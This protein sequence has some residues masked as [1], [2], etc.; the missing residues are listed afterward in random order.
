M[1][2]SLVI[3]ESPGKIKKISKFL[4]S[5]YI[6]KASVGHIADLASGRLNVDIEGGFKPKYTILS[7]KKQHVKIIISAAKH[8]EKIFLATDDDREGEAI[9]W[10]LADVLK[11]IDVPIFRVKFN[12]ITKKGVLNGINNP[13]ELDHNLYDAQ[14]AR[15]VLDRIVGFSVSPFLIK[16]FKSGFSAGRVQSVAVRMVVDK[17]KEIEVFQPEEYWVITSELAKAENK[18]DSFT[19]KYAKKVTNGDIAKKIKEDLDKDTYFVSE[20]IDNERKKKPYPPFI[21]S[22]LASTAA[23]KYKL[24][25]AKTM[26]AAQSL[27]ES[28]MITYIRT[29]SIRLSEDSIS[30]CRDWL[31]SNGYDIPHK[32]VIYV[33]KKGA[34]D[35]HEAIR[36]TDVNFTPKNVFLEKDEQLIY[37]LIWER[38]VACQMNPAVYNNVVVTIS[39]SSGHLLKAHGRTLKYKGWL[40]ISSDLED[41]ASDIKLPNLYKDD[42]LILVKPKVDAVQ[43]FTKPPS[44]F[45]EKTLIDDLK[46]KG[47]GRP[48][49]YAAIMSKITDKSYVIKKSNAF[50]PTD[51]G[52]NVVDTLTKFFEFMD[53][54]YTANMELKL[55]QIAEGKLGYIDMLTE[56]HTPFKTQLKKAY[57]SNYKD[58]GYICDI[59]ASKMVLKH[60]KFGFFLGCSDYPDCVNA[61][62]VDIVDDKPVIK[63]GKIKDPVKDVECPN[64]RSPMFKIDGRYGPFYSCIEYPMCRGTRKIPYGKKCPR[65]NNDLYA[66]VKYKSS[67]LYCMSYPDC[68]YSEKLKDSE[69]ANPKRLVARP[70]PEVVLK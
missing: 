7:D 28:G 21:T 24:S 52:K 36:P 2:K 10:H 32:S 58:Y 23:G 34:Q 37:T 15:R 20:V 49:T 47:I 12:E 9:A 59:C 48:S 43:K 8:S 54:N 33:T 13:G 18:K 4:G 55:D 65:C 41:R 69:V 40:E 70:A 6:V 64:C 16:K 1:A 5:D 57:I 22:S 11:K 19:A 56:F 38:F 25:A 27:Y 42:N 68:T 14:Q 61:I 31:Q 51:K 44:R 46:R 60:G 53:Y 30:E 17:E 35:A 67:M 63:T 50:I 26:K 45:T 62:D 3:V 29:D 66:T 39:T